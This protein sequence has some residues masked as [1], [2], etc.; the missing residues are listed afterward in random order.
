[1]ANEIERLLSNPK[2]QSEVGAFGKRFVLNEIDVKLG[3]SR[4]EEIYQTNLKNRTKLFK[5]RQ[6]LS[7]FK[8]MIPIWRDNFYHTVSTPIKKVLGMS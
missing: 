4:I 8:I 3:L 7:L 2:L 5:I 6:W 1:M